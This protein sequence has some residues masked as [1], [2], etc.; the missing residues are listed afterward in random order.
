MNHGFALQTV[1]N[2]LA[3]E[4]TFTSDCSVFRKA[5]RARPDGCLLGTL[6]R[7]CPVLPKSSLP[8]CFAVRSSVQTCLC[9]VW[10][11]QEQFPRRPAERNWRKKHRAVRDSMFR[12][13]ATGFGCAMPL[14][15][16]S[17]SCPAVFNF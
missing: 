2:G 3:S 7:R 17:L 9:F 10:F 8:C 16:M 5:S 11:L 12:V 4:D 15:A 1:G 13:T 6:S 14:S